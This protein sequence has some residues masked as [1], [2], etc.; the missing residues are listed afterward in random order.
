MPDSEIANI[1]G[2]LV[3]YYAVS[4]MITPGYREGKGELQVMAMAA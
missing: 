1:I 3:L 2:V 4:C